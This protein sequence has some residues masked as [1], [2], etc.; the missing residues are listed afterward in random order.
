MYIDSK[1]ETASTPNIAELAADYI[2]TYYK[3]A[4]VNISQKMATISAAASFSMVAALIAC[5][6]SMFMGI[7]ASLWLGG[8][9]GNTALGFLVVGLFC[10]IGFFV[11]F[12][13][14]KKIF[15]P[16]IKNRVI[17]SIYE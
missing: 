3:L 11:F 15:Y 12:F 8:L 13:T 17:K 6:V 14:R 10:L 5:F 16:F 2:D 1:N 9:M 7:A 4:I